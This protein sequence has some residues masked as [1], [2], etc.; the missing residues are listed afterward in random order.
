MD[1]TVVIPTY[2][3]K[4]VLLGTLAALA[5]S[6]YP[7]GRWE[8]VVV[9]DGSEDGTE[10][11]VEAWVRQTGAPVRY[12]RQ[13]NAGPATARNRGAQAARG[14]ALIFVD[15][16]IL[17]ERDFV[18]RHLDALAAN[19]GCWIVGA[20]RT[21]SDLATPFGR[22]LEARRSPSV[23][24]DPGSV[25]DAGREPQETQRFSAANVSLPAEHFQSLGGFDTRFTIASGE[26]W[27]L[28]V[29]AR[30]AGIRILFD[31][32]IVVQHRDWAVTLARFCERQ[33]LYSVSDCLLWRKHGARSPRARL[34]QENS[35]VD[36]RRDGLRLAAMKSLK[37]LL[38]TGPGRG[39]VAAACGMIERLAPDTYWNH[40]AYDLAVAL[41]I[42]RG[43]REGLTR[44]GQPMPSSG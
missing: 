15:N 24:R 43:V 1:A 30:R 29:R 14:R 13:A 4:D 23:E 11:G 35:P 39:L 8:A 9:D 3:R 25:P 19:P 17:V 36:W 22:Y 42:Y 21:P 38:A 28:A 6:D 5:C 41:A 32:A 40:C 44:Y 20:I 16:D 31:P 27:D 34:V 2:N 26:D 12:L 7:R 10:A 37:R 18:N 33:R